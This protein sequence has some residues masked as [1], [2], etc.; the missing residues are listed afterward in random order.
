V[1][2][3]VKVAGGRDPGRII[4]PSPEPEPE[5]RAPDAPAPARGGAGS[6][7]WRGPAPS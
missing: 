5:A 2:A 4:D 6:P 1:E 3:L 7:W